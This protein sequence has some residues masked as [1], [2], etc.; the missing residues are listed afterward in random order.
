MAQLFWGVGRQ[1]PVPE[2]PCLGE[3]R[4]QRG[5]DPGDVLQIVGRWPRR[6]GRG[7]ALSRMWL[8]Q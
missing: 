3:T 5:T 2:Y 4:G 8:L 6:T 7:V 1:V